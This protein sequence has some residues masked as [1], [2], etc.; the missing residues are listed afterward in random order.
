MNGY[1]AEVRKTHR[2]WR[3]AKAKNDA[4]EYVERYAF[5]AVRIAIERFAKQSGG[6]FC[7]LPLLFRQKLGQALAAI[8][9]REAYPL[10]TDQILQTSELIEAVLERAAF[11]AFDEAIERTRA[12]FKQLDP[13]LANEILPTPLKPIGRHPANEIEQ[14][15]PTRFAA[16]DDEARKFVDRHLAKALCIAIELFREQP[17]GSFHDLP[18][19]FNQK[20]DEALAERLSREVYPRVTHAIAQ[21]RELLDF[22]LER[23]A[24]DAFDQAR[25]AFKRVEPC[26]ADHPTPAPLKRN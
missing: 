10:A 17:E 5:Y 11:G 22:L 16:A 8:L 7:D 2:A 3:Y 26:L 12:G 6:S 18:P 1:L 14:I 20:L 13:S 9:S 25:E 15:H 21:T 4:R 24:L 19:W 23:A